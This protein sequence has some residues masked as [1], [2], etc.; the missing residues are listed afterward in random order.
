M[1]IA[2][3]DVVLLLPRVFLS[4]ELLRSVDCSSLAFFVPSPSYFLLTSG[5]K[6]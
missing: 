1:G 2:G 3:A 5:N 4:E 6:P